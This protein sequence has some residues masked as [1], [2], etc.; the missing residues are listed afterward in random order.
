MAF[1]YSLGI[2]GK[3]KF[4]IAGASKCNEV[5]VFDTSDIDDK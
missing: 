5:K 2:G 1:I 4:C 3:E